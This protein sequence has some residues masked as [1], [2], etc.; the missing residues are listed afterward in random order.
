[1][2]LEF[3]RL[4]EDNEDS[5]E[6]CSAPCGALPVPEESVLLSRRDRYGF[7]MTT[8][9]SR[10]SGVVWT[11]LR[12]SSRFL[13]IFYRNYY[14]GIYRGSSD[15]TAL[16]FN[17]QT[18]RCREIL[19]DV[20][21]NVPLESLKG[22]S[23]LDVGCGAGGMLIPFRE[24]GA[25][26]LGC[27]IGGEEGFEY[28]RSQNL[29]LRSI[30]VEALVGK[31]KFDVIN[32]SHVLEHIPEPITFLRI[33]RSLM[34]DQG[35]LII[36]VP[37]VRNLR[38]YS[39]DFLRYLQNAHLTHFS[40]HTLSRVCEAAGLEMKYVDERVIGLATKNEDPLL[41]PIWN[42]EECQKTLRYLETLE[43]IRP[44]NILWEKGRRL[45][46]FILKR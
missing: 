6:L 10:G 2:I 27:D 19:K 20:E 11:A 30:E 34:T 13:S 26:T 46:K 38:V 44:M 22:K 5:L 41:K 42:R 28:G 21:R 35:L 17:N 1:M 25:E 16:R 29:D 7:P 14:Q 33:I 24:R 36:D 37:G 12:M 15:D 43:R 40:A 18:K 32:I 8:R 4:L 39:G 45:K 3:K 23:V 31:R 9:I